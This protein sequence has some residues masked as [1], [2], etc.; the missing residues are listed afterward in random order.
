MEPN[1]TVGYF[2]M[3]IKI[4]KTTKTAEQNVHNME[5]TNTR[6]VPAAKVRGRQ[7]YLPF[8]PMKA[9]WRAQN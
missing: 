5:T 9:S 1:L 8:P 2:C 7:I 4:L 6:R 3:A